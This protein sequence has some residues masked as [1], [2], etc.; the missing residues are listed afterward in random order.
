[1]A[2]ILFKEEKTL[3]IETRKALLLS[4]SIFCLNLI[5]YYRFTLITYLEMLS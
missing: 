3:T 1:M 5:E 2:G 4:I